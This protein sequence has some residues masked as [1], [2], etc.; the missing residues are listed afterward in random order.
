[1]NM[2]MNTNG[3]S[4]FRTSSRMCSGTN[5]QLNVAYKLRE[6]QEDEEADAKTHLKSFIFKVR[7]VHSQQF[8]TLND[9]FLWELSKNGMII[10]LNKLLECY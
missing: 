8:I 7:A 9:E 4:T 2:H 3:T 1:M 10:K 6:D 5:M